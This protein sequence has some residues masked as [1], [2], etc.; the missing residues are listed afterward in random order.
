MTLSAPDIFQGAPTGLH[1]VP[2]SRMIRAILPFLF[3]AFMACTWL[4][5]KK[6]MSA[7]QCGME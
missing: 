7:N 5:L 6:T 1:A 4:I 3:H 2:N